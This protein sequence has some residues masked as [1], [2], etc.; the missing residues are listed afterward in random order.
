MKTSYYYL[1]AGLPDLYFDRENPEIGFRR[2]VGDCMEQV[3]PEDSGLLRFLLHPHDNHNLLYLLEGRKGRF[4]RSGFYS[5][6]ELEREIETE[7]SLPAYMKRLIEA[8]RKFDPVVFNTSWED[9]LSWL[10]YA[11]TERLENRFLRDW[12]TFDLNLRNLL[13]AINSREFNIPLEHRI[14]ERMERPHSQGIIGRNDVATT[15]LKSGAPDFDLEPLFPWTHRVLILER[16]DVTRFELGIDRIRW[17][18][19]EEAALFSG[20]G[21]ESLLACSLRLE[22]VD[23]WRELDAAAGRIFFDQL[24]SGMEGACRLSEFR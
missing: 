10:F 2:F 12:F 13:T 11:E 23:R 20:F 3:E 8:F 16:G 1:V 17:D 4:S 24:V 6:E 7:E 5:R 19:L 14:E 9:Q 18:Y 15:L 21:I 22:I